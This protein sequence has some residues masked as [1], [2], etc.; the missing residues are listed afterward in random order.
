[1][2]KDSQKY[3]RL[4]TEKAELTDQLKAVRSKQNDIGKEINDVTIKLKKVEKALVD[5]AT[6]DVVVTEHAILRYIQHVYGIDLEEIKEEIL[7]D[8]RKAAIEFT[9]NGKFKIKDRTLV[10]KDSVVVTIT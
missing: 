8:G 9:K 3:K 2:V 6:K 10:V 7:G 5:L 1:M 4:K